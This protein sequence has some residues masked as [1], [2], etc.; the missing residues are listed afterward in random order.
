M[1]GDLHRI[2]AA[3]VQAPPSVAVQEDRVHSRQERRALDE[4]RSYEMRDVY[5]VAFQEVSAR[6]GGSSRTRHICV[7]SLASH[8][9]PHTPRTLL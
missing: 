1:R 2:A 3:C 7:S 6:K 8:L 4:E 5:V 9:T